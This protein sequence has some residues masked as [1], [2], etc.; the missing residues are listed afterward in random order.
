MKK[1]LT[2]F[3]ASFL[4]FSCNKSLEK[5][6]D[7]INPDFEKVEASE[8][9]VQGSEDIP[10]LVGMERVSDD[11]LGFDSDSGSIVS[12]EYTSENDAKSV[13]NFYI[14]TLPQM[15][16]EVVKNLESKVVFKR[17]KENLEIEFP[18][19]DGDLQTVNFFMSSA[20]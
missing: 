8:D 10:L 19:S 1:I 6:L 18:K 5:K 4:A 16:W 20:I 11:N 13:K 17:D 9:F 7:F 15:G 3:L 14:K 12:A 2:I